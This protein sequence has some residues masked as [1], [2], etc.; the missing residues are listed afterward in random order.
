MSGG[1]LIHLTNLFAG[2]FLAI[3][4]VA[5]PLSFRYFKSA[6]YLL[7]P[8]GYEYKSHELNFSLN[9]M[10]AKMEA[11]PADPRLHS[12]REFLRAQAGE[13]DGRP[14]VVDERVRVLALCLLP[15]LI[16]VYPDATTPLIVV[17]YYITLLYY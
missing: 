13:S 8:L 1:I 6:Y 10:F 5:L 7:W 11:P 2:I 14:S 9:G 3:T 17:H 12:L 15:L 16:V 4:I